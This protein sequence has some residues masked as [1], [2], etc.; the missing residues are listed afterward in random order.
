M[1][2]AKLPY[3]KL[4]I[5]TGILVVTVLVTFLGSTVRL[6]QTVGWIPVHPIPW[7]ELPPWMGVWLGFYPSWEGILI[8]WLGVA[9]VGGAWLFV[10]WQSRRA[11]KAILAAHASELA[12]PPPAAFPQHA[13]R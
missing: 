2:G 7:L 8:P 5:V 13:A 3:R 6:F 9:Y 10:K 4:L 1:I 11:Q 12:A